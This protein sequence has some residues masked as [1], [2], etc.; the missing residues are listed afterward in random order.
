LRMPGAWV[1]AALFAVHPM[2]VES[3]AWITERKNVL[4]GVFAFNTLLVLMQATAIDR[5]TTPLHINWRLYGVACGLFA[6]ALLSKTT[7]CALPAVVLLLAWW[8][9]GT[10]E[11]RI[12]WLTAPLFA[13]G[14]LMAFA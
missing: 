13:L 4:S 2:H 10:I 9:R 12:V 5:P 3:V 6:A 8:K 7:T 11:R 1:A 14:I